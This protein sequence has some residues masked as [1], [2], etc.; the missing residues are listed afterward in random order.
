MKPER[1]RSAAGLCALLL[2][3]SPL[4]PL[5]PLSR[6]II[7]HLDCWKLARLPLWARLFRCESV[8]SMSRKGSL[9]EGIG[10]CSQP[11]PELNL[12]WS[13]SV[14]AWNLGNLIKFHRRCEA[15][16]EQTWLRESQILHSARWDWLGSRGI[17][18]R[19]RIIE[20]LRRL[21]LEAALVLA[22]WNL[23]C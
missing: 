1:A 5:R 21:I 15:E 20:L 11:R 9:R 3:V 19:Q 17:C 10:L 13:G 16:R 22:D 14:K 23:S 18:F 6:T 7:I 8:H 4:L 2:L 12:R